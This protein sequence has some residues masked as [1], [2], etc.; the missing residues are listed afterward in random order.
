MGGRVVGQARTTT[1]WEGRSFGGRYRVLTLLGSGRLT[2]ICR[3]WDETQHRH[4]AVKAAV[5]PSIHPGADDPVPREVGVLREVRHDGVVHLLDAGV[6]GDVPYLVM[7]YLGGGTLEHRRPRR[8]DG[9]ALPADVSE[10][11]HWL[12]SIAAVLDFVHG[13][14]YAHG[15]VKPTNI[16]FDGTGTPFLADFG[17]ARRDVDGDGKAADLS[18]LAATVRRWLAGAAPS[19][20]AAERSPETDAAG[21]DLA[22]SR[23]DL[24]E[25]VIAAV[26]R[27]LR[28]DPAGR[29]ATCADFA[30]A[31]LSATP[32]PTSV[33]RI[34]LVCPRCDRLLGVNP[35]SVGRRGLCPKC[36]V[37]IFVAHDLQSLELAAHRAVIGSARRI[38]R[39]EGSVVSWPG[40]GRAALVALA[41][42]AVVAFA[43]WRG[44]MREPV[45]GGADVEPAVPPPADQAVKPPEE[46]GDHAPPMPEARD[47]AAVVV[48]V[49]PAEGPLEPPDRAPDAVAEQPAPV[50][51]P[52]RVAVVVPA[53]AAAPAAVL[54]VPPDEAVAQA[55]AS[56]RDAYAADYGR[57][58]KLGHFLW[59]T[60]ALLQL[61]DE[62]PDSP[63]RYAAL[64]EVERLCLEDG[65]ISDAIDAVLRRGALFQEDTV[66]ARRAVL[67]RA[68]ESRHLAS[69][70]MCRQ[71]L[72]VGERSL[73]A[74]DFEVARAA[75]ALASR[76]ASALDADGA[77]DYRDRSADLARA[78]DERQRSFDAYEAARGEL[79]ADPADT[80]ASG[81][82]GTYLCLERHD[83]K[84]GVPY[85]AASDLPDVAGIARRHLAAT[86]EEPQDPRKVMAVA[87]E[88]WRVAEGEIAGAWSGGRARAVRVFASSL[89]ASIFDTLDDPFERRLAAERAG[90]SA[91]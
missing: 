31:V 51:P 69:P 6:D 84:Q 8:D 20:A 46:P 81:T 49:P 15:D 90:R 91:R 44:G 33:D 53:A 54:Q 17:A 88:W 59:L 7:P 55:A 40:I 48:E 60:E 63:R 87:D 79:E 68:L 42:M 30:A 47:A 28:P 65:R 56:L 25:V 27:G 38:R 32:R 58:A 89:Y 35:A 75:L 76:A 9:P 13:R 43:R 36:K 64:R 57:A 72:A 77:A 5:C 50:A 80:A 73:E 4:V 83:W 2:A 22:T 26:A 12:P 21:P 14:G 70:G 61:V 23:P 16:L 24:P 11:W 74:E 3:A 66:S 85:L 41:L 86:R 78:I 18:A 29:F 45:A 39:R 71:A 67:E 62:S 34:Q 52:A 82:V 37:G 10:L 1:G 19:G